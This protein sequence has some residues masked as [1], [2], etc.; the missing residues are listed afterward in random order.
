MAATTSTMTTVEC[1][2]QV[3]SWRLLRSLIQL[4]I[5][6]CSCT[7]LQHNHPNIPPPR[8]PPLTSTI[9]IF[10]HRTRGKVKFGIQYSSNN[11]QSPFLLLELPLTTSLLAKEMRGGSLRMALET[12]AS[13]ANNNSILSTP[14][15]SVHCNGRKMG[16]AVKRAPSREDL[17]ALDAMRSVVVGAGVVKEKDVNNGEDRGDE[18]GD[19]DDDEGEEEEEEEDDDDDDVMYLRAKF[20]RVRGSSNSESFHLIDPEGS[21]G[22]ELS[23]FF[24][25]ST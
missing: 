10:G 9:T 18:E 23:I 21:I 15:W 17:R 20:R 16:Y 13:P 11:P 3:R 25:R 22:Q 4:L 2:K 1:H 12:A 7:F 8:L 6:T 24:F 19:E 14:L 5:P